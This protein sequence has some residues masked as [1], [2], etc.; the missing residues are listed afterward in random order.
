M[1]KELAVERDAHFG[2]ENL[3]ILATQSGFGSISHFLQYVATPFAWIC[4]NASKGEV[5][6]SRF[7]VVTFLLLQLNSQICDDD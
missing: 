3:K 5:I 1:I 7:E 4:V 6:V 2:Q